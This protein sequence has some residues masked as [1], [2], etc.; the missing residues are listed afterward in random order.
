MNE[1]PLHLLP[2]RFRAEISERLNEGRDE[3]ELAVKIVG[4]LDPYCRFM[5]GERLKK[6]QRRLDPNC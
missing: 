3:D 2:S 1:E 4:E 5:Y 6:V